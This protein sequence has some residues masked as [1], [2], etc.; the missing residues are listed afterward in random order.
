MSIANLVPAGVNPSPEQQNVLLEIAYLTTAADGQL[1]D[2][3]L[4]AFKQIIS[5]LRGTKATD[6]DVDALLDKFAGA[7]EPE[8]IAAR[9][10]KIAPT[11]P[12]D[13]K[14]IAYK[15]AVGLGVA[16]MDAHDDEAELQVVLAEALGFD[17]AK[18]DALT[19]EVYGSLDAGEEK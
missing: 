18:V 12:S 10:Q 6:A 19:E 11:L 8:E 7:V 3:E 17:D 16:D 14:D 2:E 5:R 9:V 1:R 4:A 13:L 15:L